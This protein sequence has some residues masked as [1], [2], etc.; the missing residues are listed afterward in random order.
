M[1]VVTPAESQSILGGVCV[2]GGGGTGGGGG[3]GGGGGERSASIQH[4]GKQ[5]VLDVLQHQLAET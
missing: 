3:G 1:T 5:G 4:H 2:G